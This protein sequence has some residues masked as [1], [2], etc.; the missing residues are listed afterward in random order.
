MPMAKAWRT[1]SLSKGAIGVV[2]AKVEDVGAGAC[3]QRQVG[4]GF[5]DSEII[6]TGVVDA[7]HLAGLQFQQ[8]LGCF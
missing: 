5:D 2:H 3:V 8:A 6:G 4:I 1:R 7:L